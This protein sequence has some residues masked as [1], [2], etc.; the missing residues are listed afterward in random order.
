MESSEP[1]DFIPYLRS[2]TDEL[3]VT[4]NRVR[5]LVNHWPTDGHFKEAVLRHFLR[6]YLPESV[7]I[8]TGFVVN[9]F[10]PS[11]EIDILVVDKEMPT[12]FKDGELLIVTPESVRAVI[13]VKTRLSS[14]SEIKE[15]VLQLAVRKA[16]VARHVQCQN[17]WAGLLVY[18]GED[19]RHH[20]L[21]EALHQVQCEQRTLVDF[22]CYGEDTVVKYFGMPV[23]V[24]AIWPD[25]AW[26]S[27][28]MLGVAPTNFVASLIEHLVPPKKDLGS[29]AWFRPPQEFERRFFI[30]R[31]PASTVM[32][33]SAWIKDN[34]MPMLSFGQQN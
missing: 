27:F 15:A 21:L 17:V 14:P 9:H 32:D 33:Y 19:D 1:H 13:E 28:H 31:K 2:I 20:A 26:H 34:P 3:N 18:E 29:F 23:E 6:R 4:K 5:Q 24:S 11:G 25:H 22:V 10:G 12:L 16:V 30:K 7:L 8:G